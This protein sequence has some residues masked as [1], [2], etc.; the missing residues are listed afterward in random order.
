V[1]L[2]GEHTD[3]T[4]G[5]VLPLAIDRTT[6]AVASRRF[7]GIF[8]IVSSQ[9]REPFRTSAREAPAPS[10]TRWANYV[11][12]VIAELWDRADLRGGARIQIDG[13]IPFG[14]GLS[15]SASLMVACGKALDE[16]FDGGLTDL[17][18]AKACRR[19]EHRF[20]GVRCG[21]MDH[22]AAAVST[23]GHALLLDCE[24]LQTRAVPFPDV[25][26]F[27]VHSGIRHAL[28][29]TDYNR[30]VSECERVL[31]EAASWSWRA[32]ISTAELDGLLRRLPEPLDRRARHVILENKR[33]EEGAELLERGDVEAFG[34][35]MYASHASLRDL[36][37]VSCPELDRIV[38]AL[39]P[40]AFGAKMTGAGFGGAVVALVARDRLE[41]A[42]AAVA[43]AP[44]ALV[45]VPYRGS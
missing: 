12:G 10:E 15:S 5:L 31:M 16:L 9:E 36:Y 43:H 37:E 7:D 38:E 1:N 40:V 30:R 42:R 29:D 24:S 23:P 4:G 26:V 11:L 28:A 25:A 33:V 17:E 18:L 14:A 2:L 39:R 22:M 34:R 20:A 6:R 35:L 32:D 13:D 21:I 19:A 41:A 44:L 8:E 45:C 27:V 3:Y